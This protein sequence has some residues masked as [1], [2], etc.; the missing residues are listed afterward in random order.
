MIDSKD[1]DFSFSGLK[2]AVLYLVKERFMRQKKLVISDVQLANLC[3]EFQQAIIDVLIT[4]TMRAAKKYS[5][6]TVILGGGVAANRE[7]RKQLGEAIAHEFK[8]ITYV[9]PPPSLAV[10]NA[11]MIA[12]TGYFRYLEGAATDWRRIR[13]RATI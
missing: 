4:K 13:A 6:K 7:L 3:A 5:V 9:V 10:D 2:T 8:K 12:I 11:V 1:Y